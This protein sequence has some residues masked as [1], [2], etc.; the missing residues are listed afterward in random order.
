MRV[1]LT[2]T[3]GPHAGTEFHFERHDTFVVGRSKYAH[4]RPAQEDRYFSRIHFMLEVNPP[5]CRLIDMGSHNGTYVNGQRVLSCDL[6]E[7]DQIRAGH[8]VLRLSVP[9]VAKDES[10]APEPPPEST[11]P[12]VGQPLF[13]GYATIAALEPDGLGHLYRARRL[14]DGGDITVRAFVP[15][16]Q[17]TPAQLDDFFR[18]ARFLL[19]LEHPHLVRLCDLGYDAGQLWFVSDHSVGGDA[20]SIVR[21][22]GPL[23]IPRAVRWA[24]QVLLALKYAHGLHFVH[25]DIKPANWAV[26]GPRG[27]EV[28]RLADFG[29]AR[30]YHLAP[31]SGLSITADILAAAAFLPPEVLLSYQDARPASDQY[32]VAATLY[33]LLAGTYAINLPPEV[34]RRFTSLLRQQLVPLRERRAD[35]PQKLA[36]VIHKAMAREPAQRFKS[37]VEF[38]QALLE[39]VQE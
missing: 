34:N 26:T 31:F 15:S 22:D 17:P 21:R 10:R 9:A 11:T 12:T 5:R 19:K 3:A 2:V 18:S 39:A 27:R 35:V 20:A 33:Y 23:P 25:G 14:A 36:D 16:H 4:F 1:T 6:H 28:V 24:S 30:A 29:I 7:G 13:P 32:A 38:R 8:T 37:V